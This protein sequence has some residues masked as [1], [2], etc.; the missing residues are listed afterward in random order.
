MSQ[1]ITI[2]NED[3]LQQVKLSYKIPEI[4]EQIVN[5]QIIT[6]AANEAGITV[7]TEELQETA[8]KFRFMNKLLGADETW[9]WLNKHSLSL[10][11]FEEIV[12]YTVLSGKLTA[13]LFADKVEPYFYEHQLDYASA[14]I[15]EMVVDD[16]DLATELFYAI[17]EEEMSF[18][19]VAQQ[20]IQDVELRRKGGYRGI[21]QR[22][23]MKP[24]ISAAVF[25][26]TPPQ[27]LKPILTS[28]G[29]HLILVEEIIQPKLDEKV[30]LEII[31]SLF[32]EWLNR[33]FEKVEIVSK[34]ELNNKID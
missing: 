21:V 16:E 5:R 1:V 23:E 3:I 34:L 10:D 31:S 25:A 28:K 22:Q 12:H 19:E 18:Y 24:E 9:K 17:T 29:V 14:V 11:D 26:A 33:E 15:Y 8:N 6:T 2:T 7:E 27:M 20:Y 4:I 30:R 32:A 13:H